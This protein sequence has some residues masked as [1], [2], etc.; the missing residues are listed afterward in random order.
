MEKLIREFADKRNLAE[1]VSSHLEE[2]KGMSIEEIMDC[3]L[4]E[5]QIRKK[6]VYLPFYEEKEMKYDIYFKMISPRLDYSHEIVCAIEFRGKED[7]LRPG[8]LPAVAGMSL[9]LF[10]Q[11]KEENLNKSVSERCYGFYIYLEAREDLWGRENRFNVHIKVEKKDLL[12]E[13]ACVGTEI[14]L[15]NKE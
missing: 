7:Y 10:M 6:K 12:S 3:F 4:G 15:E 2:F 1:L 8:E 13:H 9:L 5:P 14:Y 11:S